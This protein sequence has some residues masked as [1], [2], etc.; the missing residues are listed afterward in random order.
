MTAGEPQLP[1]V[2]VARAGS[3]RADTDD[4]TARPAINAEN[5]AT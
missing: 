4:A 5:I 3:T 1:N 2:L